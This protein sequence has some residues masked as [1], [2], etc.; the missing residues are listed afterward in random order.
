MKSVYSNYEEEYCCDLKNI[1]A[2]EDIQ[3]SNYRIASFDIECDSSHGEFPNPKKDF[4]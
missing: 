1:V 3:T 4:N 2:I